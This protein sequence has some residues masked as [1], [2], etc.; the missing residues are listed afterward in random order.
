MYILVHL[1]NT[2]QQYSIKLQS[3]STMPEISPS[4]LVIN[5]TQPWSQK[6]SS[7]ITEHFYNTRTLP[8][9]TCGQF[10]SVLVPEKQ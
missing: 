1:S 10:Y 6:H 3:I 8:L 4:S 7:Q 2:E 9:T 5:S